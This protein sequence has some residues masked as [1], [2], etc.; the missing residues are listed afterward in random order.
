MIAEDLLLLALHDKKGGKES[1]IQALES[2][3][4]GALIVDL[5]LLKKNPNS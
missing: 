1:G 2:G 5:G 3:L 4:P